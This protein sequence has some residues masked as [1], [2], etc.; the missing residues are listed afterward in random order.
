MSSISP[1]NRRRRRGAAAIA[2]ALAVGLCGSAG[3]RAQDNNAAMPPSQQQSAVTTLFPGG[4]AM[5]PL[6][7]I[8]QKYDGN[9]QAINTGARLFD[10]YNCSGCHFHGAGGIGPSLMDDQ[11]I[12]GGRI[13]QIYDSIARGRP[14][15]MPSWQGKIP[16]NEIWQIAAYVRSL[17]A[18]EPTKG[19]AGEAEPVPAPPPLGSP[20]P[21]TPQTVTGIDK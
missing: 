13:D 2:A 11:W 4:G 6:D 14:N 10:W 8:A 3:L 17:S 18:A 5:P 1:T 9:A 21:P 20:P 12:Y 7:P 16:P 19:G 15:G